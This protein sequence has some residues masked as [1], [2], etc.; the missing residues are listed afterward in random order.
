MSFIGVL[1]RPK[2]DRQR[3]RKLYNSLQVGEREVPSVCNKSWGC[4]SGGRVLSAHKALGSLPSITE[5]IFSKP[6][7]EVEADENI[8]VT[9]DSSPWEKWW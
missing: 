6:E 1:R 9:R 7:T 2:V 3:T 4:S 5:R 8:N